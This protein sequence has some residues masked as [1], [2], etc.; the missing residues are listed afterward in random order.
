[1]VAGILI[2]KKQLFARNKFLA[3]S[4]SDF[5]AAPGVVAGRRRGGARRADQR[6]LRTTRPAGGRPK[7]A[8]P[9]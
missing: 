8:L 3:T 7:K 1:L 6:E 4:A 9:Y 5:S 2:E